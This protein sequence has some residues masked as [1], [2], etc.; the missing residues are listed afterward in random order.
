MPA[1]EQ[2]ANAY[3]G[4]AMALR[5]KLYTRETTDAVL[6]PLDPSTPVWYAIARHDGGRHLYTS[7]QLTPVTEGA[8]TVVYVE[9][10]REDTLALPR[11]RRPDGSFSV[12][13]PLGLRH[14]IYTV[15]SN[16]AV[17]DDRVLM[18]GT[19]YLYNALIAEHE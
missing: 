6:T 19:L 8:D 16:P 1:T 18:T 14:S 9:V 5:V 3:R 7:E 10:S 2:D 12:P 11:P 4:A 13:V 17:N 15:D